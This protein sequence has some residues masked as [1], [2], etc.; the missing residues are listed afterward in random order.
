MA[1]GRLLVGPNVKVLV[2]PGREQSVTS[3][4]WPTTT[5]GGRGACGRRRLTGGTWYDDEAPPSTLTN[6]RAEVEKKQGEREKGM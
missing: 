2:F 4:P 1:W 5:R 3:W 6:E